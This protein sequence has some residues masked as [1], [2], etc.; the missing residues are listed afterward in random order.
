MVGTASWTDK[1]LIDSKLFYPPDVKSPEDRLRFYASRFPMVEVDSSYYAIPDVRSARQW[2]E[3]TPKAFEFNVKAFRI[4][5]GHQTPIRVFPTELRETIAEQFPK[6]KNVYYKDLT[7]DLRKELWRDFK[8]MLAPLREAGKLTAVHFQ[9]APWVI[10]SPDG[11]RHI[12]EV[13]DRMDGYQLAFEFR[14]RTWYNG[15]HD[16]KTIATE[17]E[18]GVAHVV[19]DG[20]VKSTLSIPQVWEVASPNLAIVRLHGR[21]E[22]TWD[23]KGL[24]AASDRFDYDYTKKELRPIARKVE[25]LAEEAKQVHVVFNNNKGDQNVRGAKMMQELLGQA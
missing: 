23:K 20:P 17:R 18:L 4:F 9:F 8:A 12:E 14:N 10:P 15:E 13:A 11:K 5:T 2:A 3:R 6:R 19:V 1:S 16:H 24:T 21:N 22:E 25:E 7:E